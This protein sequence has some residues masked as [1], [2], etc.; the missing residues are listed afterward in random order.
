[1]TNNTDHSWKL[2]CVMNYIKHGDKAFYG[3]GGHRSW[4]SNGFIYRIERGGH[5]RR[6]I[7]ARINVQT[8]WIGCTDW[9]LER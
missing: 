2:E 8:E 4:T 6:I 9:K 5:T 3:L 7:G 1:M